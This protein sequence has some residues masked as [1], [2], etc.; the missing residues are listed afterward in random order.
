MIEN[1]F[2]I[3]NYIKFDQNKTVNLFN[4]E[5][6][7]EFITWLKNHLIIYLSVNNKIKTNPMQL[8]IK[9][10]SSYFIQKCAI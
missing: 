8:I 2:I 9:C 5:N 7:Q 4:T 1:R 10:I 3:H 6:C